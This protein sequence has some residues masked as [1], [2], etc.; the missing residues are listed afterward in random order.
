MTLTTTIGG[1]A[2]AIKDRSLQISAVAN[3]RDTLRVTVPSR[4]GT[5]RPAVGAE[6]IVEVDAVRIFGGYVTTPRE[7]GAGNIGLTPIWTSVSAVAF[8]SV[9]DRRHVTATVADGTSLEDFL[10][11]LATYL[12]AGFSLSGSQATGPALTAMQFDGVRLSEVL[13]ELAKITG[14]IWD[15]SYSKVLSMF[16]PTGVAAPFNIT[17]AGRQAKGDVTVERSRDQYAN[18]VIV[19]AGGD[20]IVDKIDTF[21]GDGAEDTFELN[22]PMVYSPTVGYGYVWNGD[23]PGDPGNPLYETLDLA[24]NGATWEYNPATNEIVRVAGAPANGNLVTITYPAQFPIFVQA[25]DTVEQAAEGI[26]EIVL[27]EPNVYLREQAQEIADTALARMTAITETVRYVTHLAGLRPGM[28]QTITLPTRDLSGSY[29]ITGVE[30]SNGIGEDELAYDVTAVGGDEFRGTWRDVYTSWLG[31]GGT[32]S[33]ASSPAV[34]SGGGSPCPPQKAVQFY[35]SGQFG[36]DAAFTYDEDTNS[37]VCGD[38]SSITAEYHESCQVFGSDC[39][40][41]DF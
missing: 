13:N 32:T 24:G 1:V 25:D 30:I 26:W 12:P 9:A 22:Y 41:T 14:W 10:I 29:L 3:G 18:R 6:I 40:I 7:T 28:V 36:G 35:R 2:K 11:V 34:G 33:A 15:I 19:R 23:D 4:A 20:A 31:G 5:Y 21:T 38:G 37:L 8:K 17:F 27:S 39:H 16:D